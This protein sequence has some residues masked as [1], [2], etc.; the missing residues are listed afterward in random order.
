MALFVGRLNSRIHKQDLERK[1]EKYGRLTRCDLKPQGFAFITYEDIRD[2]EDAM[3][4]LQ[5]SEISGCRI[6]IEWS[7]ESGRYHRNAFF[8]EDDNSPSRSRSKSKSK[9]RSRSSSASSS[10]YRSDS[11]SH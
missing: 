6:N 8:R 4:E 9:S 7:K 3:T 1:F 2:A 10:Y 11:H 5:G